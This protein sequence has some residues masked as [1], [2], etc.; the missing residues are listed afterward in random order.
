MKAV[1]HLYDVESLEPRQLLSS[2]DLGLAGPAGG[3]ATDSVSD[4]TTAYYFSPGSAS[5]SWDIWKTD[6]SAAGTQKLGTIANANSSPNSFVLSGGKLFFLAGESGSYARELYTYDATAAA[7]VKLGDLSPSGSYNGANHL[8]AF[9]NKA[10]VIGYTNATGYELFESDGT[11]AGTKHSVDLNAGDSVV[12]LWQAN[13]TLYVAGENASNGL[14]VYQSDGTQA[15]TTLLKQLSTSGSQYGQLDGFVTAGSHVV[16]SQYNG[17]A[18][19]LWTTDGT[20]AGTQTITTQPGGAQFISAGDFALYMGSTVYQTDGTNSGTKKLTGMALPSYFANFFAAS[21]GVAYVPTDSGLYRVTST[22]ATEI[23]F[24]TA[25]EPFTIDDRVYFAGTYRGPTLLQDAVAVSDGTVA[26]TQLLEDRDLTVGGPIPVSFRKTANGII[27]GL[28]NKLYCLSPDQAPLPSVSG[29]V[30]RDANQNG[31]RDAGEIGEGSVSLTPTLATDSSTGFFQAKWL[32]PGTFNLQAKTSV[33]YVV[34]TTSTSLSFNLAEGDVITGANFGFRRVNIIRG[35]V[36]VDQNVNDV[37]DSGEPAAPG[38]TVYIDLDRDGVVDAGEPHTTSAA[39]G[40]FEFYDAPVGKLL[41]R[42]APQTGW[43]VS[44]PIA[45]GFE[46]TTTADGGVFNPGKFAVTQTPPRNY[47]SA[48]AFE[49]LNRNGIRDAGEINAALPQFWVDLNDNG[50]KDSNEPGPF[51]NASTYT[52]LLPGPGTYRVR[53][54]AP[55]GWVATTTDPIVTLGPGERAFDLPMGVAVPAPSGN[56]L[57]G[58]AFFDTNG[59]GVFDSGETVRSGVRMYNDLDGDF[60]FDSNEPSVITDSLGRFAMVNLDAGDY[61]LR[62]EITDATFEQ[63]APN[64]GEALNVTLADGEQRTDLQFGGRYWQAN[65]SVPGAG[66]DSVS[67]ALY[68]DD[69]VNGVRDSGENAPTGDDFEVYVDLNNDNF[70]QQNEPA[71]PA[72]S[73]KYNLAGLAPGKYHLRFLASLLSFNPSTYDQSTGAIFEIAG[74]QS[75]TIDIGIY[76]PNGVISGGVFDPSK[77]PLQV[78]LTWD[79]LPNGGNGLLSALRVTDSAGNSITPSSKQFAANHQIVISFNNKLA[80]GAYRLTIPGTALHGSSG[81]PTPPDYTFDFNV[82]AG[83][84][85]GSGQVDI[86]DFNILAANFGKTGMTFSQGN[87]DYS[88]DKT[89]TIT[90]FNVLAANFGKSV[91]TQTQ[92]MPTVNSFASTSTTPEQLQLLKPLDRSY[93]LEII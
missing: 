93:L 13:N 72:F 2:T 66:N 17:T 4:G 81:L 48:T 23:F 26:G 65:D 16:F 43:Y 32:V 84:G 3:G 55:P 30:F 10:Y 70:R 85:D 87:Y 24:D 34:P 78:R 90:D 36:V 22:S 46:V 1:S 92:A 58:V 68:L 88:S 71:A 64:P 15:G 79:V 6:G 80:D 61:S 59:N 69:N 9:N 31:V 25:H 35:S 18:N 19:V 63:T 57:A 44:A 40:S 12:G 41:V 54:Q 20:A 42:V 76:S 37:A 45:P 47:L 39:D 21:N 14:A 83:D 53:F 28:N 27:Y 75:R 60:A 89:V 5:Y 29:Y 73:G 7:I 67:G 74:S 91:A 11:V 77:L 56:T 49:D 50:V 51:P 8:V 62:Q 33:E 86:K 52:A 82:L 38:Q